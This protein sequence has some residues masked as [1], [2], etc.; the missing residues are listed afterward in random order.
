M[1]VVLQD[2][3]KLLLCNQIKQY[4]GKEVKK[5]KI[6]DGLMPRIF[7]AISIPL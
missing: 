6:T 5:I 7:L 1:K 4:S 2:N 3:Q